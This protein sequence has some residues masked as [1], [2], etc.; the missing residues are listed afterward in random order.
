MTRVLVAGTRVMS[1]RTAAET[2]PLVD[3]LVAAGV[4]AAT[5]PW[6]DPSVDWTAADLVAVRTTWDYTSRRGEFLAWARAVDAGTSLQ[7]PLGVLEWNSHK[8]YLLD[9]ASAG[10]PVV[11]TTLVPAG[12]PDPAAFLGR[13]RQVVK[14]AVSAGGRGAHLG[15]GPGGTDGLAAALARLVAEG[16]A[17]V[18]PAVGSVGDEGEVSLV[19][20][21]EAW[22]HAVRKLPPAGGFLVHER[23]GGRLEDHTPTAAEVAVAEAA[24]ACAPAPVHAARVDL[25]RLDGGPVVMELELI[26]PELFLRRAPGAAAR[27]AAALLARL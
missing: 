5:H 21:G 11:P 19:R 7:N 14:P 26:E 8:A 24:L 16:D 9:L 25:V 18:Q 2:R 22:S 12:D 20:L 6:D 23:H 15:D 13:G 10:V 3:A 1:E 17:L 4:D 27:L